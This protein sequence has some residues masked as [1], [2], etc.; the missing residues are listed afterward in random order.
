MFSRL[1]L[2]NDMCIWFWR[3]MSF[4]ISL[5]RTPNLSKQI[6]HYLNLNR[7]KETENKH[8]PWISYP[9][10]LSHVPSLS[11]HEPLSQKLGQQLCGHFQFCVQ[12]LYGDS[13]FPYFPGGWL[14]DDCGKQVQHCL[15][16]HLQNC[17]AAGSVWHLNHLPLTAHEDLNQSAKKEL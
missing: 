2:V 10:S 13:H 6:S 7:K 17:V 12:L 5:K 9:S 8:Q 14:G 1:R 16:I 4:Y 3:T 11:Q 15:D